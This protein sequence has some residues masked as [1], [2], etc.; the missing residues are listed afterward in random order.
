MISSIKKN[1]TLTFLLIVSFF[2]FVFPFVTMAQGG[3]IQGLTY[4]CPGDGNCSWG[5]VVAAL[6]NL[7]NKATLIAIGFS[8]VVIAIAGGKYMISGDNPGERKAANKMLF[9]V[10]KGM[11]FILLAWLIVTLILTALGVDSIVQLG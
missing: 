4:I 11:V 7:V 2:L 6:R 9:S 1:N 5:D 3:T 10:I 8:V